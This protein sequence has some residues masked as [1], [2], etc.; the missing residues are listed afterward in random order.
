MESR[1]SAFR[2]VLLIVQGLAILVVLVLAAPTLR[3][4]R[5]DD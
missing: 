2:I 5:D 3:K 1:T 4:A